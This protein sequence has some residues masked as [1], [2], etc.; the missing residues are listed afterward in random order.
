MSVVGGST[1]QVYQIAFQ[2]VKMIFE[3]PQ[4]MLEALLR[5]I[6]RQKGSRAADIQARLAA[7]DEKYKK[8][9]QENSLV[10]NEDFYEMRDSMFGKKALGPQVILSFE[11]YEDMM[12]C[13]E[14]LQ[15]KRIYH[16]VEDRSGNGLMDGNGTFELELFETDAKTALD[17]LKSQGLDAK[18]KEIVRFG[19]E[20]TYIQGKLLPAKDVSG[21]KLEKGDELTCYVLNDKEELSRFNENRSNIFCSP[22]LV[23][24]DPDTGLPTLIINSKDAGKMDQTLSTVKIQARKIEHFKLRDNNVREKTIKISFASKED[25]N[26]FLANNGLAEKTV[27]ENGQ[28]SYALSDANVLKERMIS[29]NANSIIVTD[30]QFDKFESK[31]FSSVNGVQEAWFSIP[32]VS[33]SLP[34]DL[35]TSAPVME[36]SNSQF[37]EMY[38]FSEV[39]VLDVDT[40]FKKTLDGEKTSLGQIS[41]DHTIAEIDAMKDN[42][43]AQFEDNL[44]TARI[45]YTVYGRTVVIPAEHNGIN[46]GKALDGFYAE[47]TSES[48]I[49]GISTQV[50]SY[51]IS[52]PEMEDIFKTTHSGKGILFTLDGVDKFELVN[53]LDNNKEKYCFTADGKYIFLNSKGVSPEFDKFKPQLTSNAKFTDLV[54][55]HAKN[56]KRPLDDIQL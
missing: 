30:E 9:Y 6:E 52:L 54:D 35:N 20:S 47:K 51:E 15:D 43:V 5:T 31:D 56:I 28:V 49:S 4:K 1:D 45:P 32:L 13:S 55:I 17:S 14:A 38:G 16:T 24:E 19:E 22:Y 10:S 12:E 39:Y 33:T 41:R 18:I 11:S 40:L 44:N 53:V 21:L 29:I 34:S 37:C 46:Y 36:V 25:R 7:E 26:E 3:G 8:L 48:E 27:D 50:Q 2:G 23:R 42:F